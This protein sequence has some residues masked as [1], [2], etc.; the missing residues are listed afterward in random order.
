[1][2]LE[3]NNVSSASFI[4]CSRKLHFSF[5]FCVFVQKCGESRS[6]RSSCGCSKYVIKDV[7][8]SI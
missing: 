1:M 8:G 5:F 2:I 3:K 4:V 6:Y 7:M